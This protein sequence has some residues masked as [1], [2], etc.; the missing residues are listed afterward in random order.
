M[1]VTQLWLLL[2]RILVYFYFDCYNFHCGSKDWTY[3]NKKK[4]WILITII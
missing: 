2:I 1:Y 4:Q 3:Q